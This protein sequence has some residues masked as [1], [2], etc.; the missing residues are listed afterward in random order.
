MTFPEQLRA[1]RARL[2]LT[3]NQAAAILDVPAR[4][5][6]EWEHGKTEPYAITQEGAMARL[7]KREDLPPT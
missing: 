5:Y 2:K 6:W 4:T 1:H 7:E 3:Q